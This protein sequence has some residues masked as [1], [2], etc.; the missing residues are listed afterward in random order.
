MYR[1]DV[2]ADKYTQDNTHR[3]GEI[4]ITSP[5]QQCLTAD[6]EL[7]PSA[8][9]FDYVI[10]NQVLEHAKNF[11]QFI[12]ETRVGKRGYIETPSMLGELMFP[13]SRTNG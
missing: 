7:L 4:P 12:A 10:R 8:K 11:E 9:A 3:C 1:S 2:I 6:G 13:K 5:H